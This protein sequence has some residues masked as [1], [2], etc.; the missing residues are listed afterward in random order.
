MDA[1]YL[2]ELG[3]PVRPL[4]EEESFEAEAICAYGTIE[5]VRLYTGFFD[6]HGVRI[7]PGDEWMIRPSLRDV[8]LA[9]RKQNRKINAGLESKNPRE[10]LDIRNESARLQLILCRNY[11]Q[12]TL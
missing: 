11:P 8:W 3:V 10:L 1:Q 5:G 6:E 7:R 4:P 12:Q 9:L 2:D